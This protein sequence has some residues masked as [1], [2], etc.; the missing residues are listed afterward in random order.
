MRLMSGNNDIPAKKW[1]GNAAPECPESGPR[2]PSS[3]G[4]AAAQCGKAMPFRTIYFVP[5]RLCL[6][7][8]VASGITSNSL[9]KAEP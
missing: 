2:Q 9:G 6:G 8:G 3:R 1:S 7:G 5:P 4:S